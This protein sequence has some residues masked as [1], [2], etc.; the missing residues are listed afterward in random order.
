M[1][2]CE[3]DFFFVIACE[4]CCCGH[5]DLPNPVLL[6]LINCWSSVVSSIVLPQFVQSPLSKKF[7]RE[8]ASDLGP[9]SDSISSTAGPNSTRKRNEGRIEDRDCTWKDKIKTSRGG[10]GGESYSMLVLLLSK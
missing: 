10:R 2:F 4:Y 7:T 5:P 9:F 8:K 1:I 6:F 3:E